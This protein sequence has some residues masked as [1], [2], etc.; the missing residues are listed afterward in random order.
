MH[1]LSRVKSLVVKR[2]FHLARSAILTQ[3]AGFG[4]NVVA[5]L[6]FWMGQRFVVIGPQR[7]EG[8]RKHRGMRGGRDFGAGVLHIFSVGLI[9]CAGRWFG[10]ITSFRRTAETGAIIRFQPVEGCGLIRV[11]SKPVTVLNELIAFFRIIP[12]AAAF[13]IIR[14]VLDLRRR[15]RRAVGQQP[16]ADVV[17]IFSGLH[18]GFKLVG[19]D[20]F[21]TEKLPVQWTIIAIFAERARQA[22][23]AFVHGPA[24]EGESPEAVART[25]RCLQAQVQVNDACVHVFD[26]VGKVLCPVM[27]TVDSREIA[28]RDQIRLRLQPML[29]LVTRLGTLIFISEVSFPGHFVR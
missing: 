15:L 14:P 28:F 22:G 2:R 4:K 11:Q 6:G 23:A 12:Q 27:E 7:V 24:G 10:G 5:F 25:V 19:G 13:L 8:L 20:A 21:E 16:G 18:G 1:K 26:L 9:G 3:V 17:I 29:H